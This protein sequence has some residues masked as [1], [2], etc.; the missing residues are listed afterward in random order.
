MDLARLQEV[1]ERTYG[2]RDRARG[3]P[4][5]VAWLAEE[6]GELA[7]AVRKGTHAQREHEFADVVAWVASLANQMDVDLAAAV[8]R[9]ADGCPRCAG[10]PCTCP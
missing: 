8:E 4:S 10:S 5:T 2:E 1:I 7:Q 3:V 6:V 9:Y